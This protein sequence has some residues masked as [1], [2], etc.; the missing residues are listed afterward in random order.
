MVRG[1]KLNNNNIIRIR[2]ALLNTSTHTNSEPAIKVQEEEHSGTQPQATTTTPKPK[3]EPFVK[4][5]FL[6]K[7]DK[8]VL[9]YPEVLDQERHELLHEMVVPIER[10]ID[11]QV[12]GAKI[13]HEAKIPEETLEGLKSLGLYGQQI[14]EE[15]GGLGLGATEYARIAEITS[16]DGSIAVTLAAHQ[17]IG[18]KGIIIAGTEAQKAKYLPRLA[19]GEWTAAFC[20]TEPSS[21]SD[22]ASIQ[23]R[24]TLSEDGKTWTINGNK[25]WISNGGYA[26]LMT[27]FAKTKEVQ[28]DGTIKDKVTAF[29]VERNFGG[30][31]SGPPE[32]KLG[33]RGSNTCE[34]FFDNVPVP[35]EN[36]IGEVGGGFKVA[37]N[38]LN[39]GR[40]SMGSSGAGILKRVMKWA[41]EHATTRH[42]FSRPLS[43][44]ALIKEKFARMSVNIY[45]M[46]SMA[47]L[48]AGILDGTQDPDC[49]VEAAMVKVFS[50][51]G[52]WKWS[53]ECLQVLGGLGYTKSYP[54]ERYLRDARILLI[55]EG[56]NEI[57]RLFIGLS[58]LQHAGL[59]LRNLVK[60]LRNP[61]MN[62]GFIL[63]KG[64]ERFRQS[65]DNPKLDLDLSGHL[66][67][68]LMGGA[69]ILEYCV[70][71]FQYAV[72]TVLAR[73]GLEVAHPA[74]QL[75]VAR[76][77]DCAIDLYAMTAVLSRAS[78]SHCI[79]IHKSDHELKMALF[80]CE[81]ASRRVRIAVKDIEDGPFNSGDNVIT[82]IADEVLNNGGYVAGHPLTRTYW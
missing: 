43:D 44:F 21:G 1:N 79:G 56:T 59:E 20:L 13:D 26:D 25:I 55:F 51:E 50:S 46:E 15:Y 17:A 81:E 65:K 18:L 36:V 35:A 6:G 2:T 68:S 80:F 72:E 67:P 19:T 63:G 77:A 53:S 14:P 38:I 69:E 74:N 75:E 29:I 62:P 61:L 73:Y 9:A 23:T 64:I 48:T 7:F 30:V 5:L 8:N 76:L 28:R 32:D 37:M 78:R 45:A 22:A 82:E 58:G 52:A 42:Q 40:F 71:R 4:N 41:I 24:A 27:V 31:N 47:Y 57:L 11:E 39:S 34:V 3:R 10:F 70:K 16:L 54:F 33:I 60:K 66:H 49:S 12:D